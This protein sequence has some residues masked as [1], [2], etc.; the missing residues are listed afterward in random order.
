[1]F[2]PSERPTLR[3]ADILENIDRIQAYAGGMDWP[4]FQADG[5]RRDAIERC[6]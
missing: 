3:F 2:V 5:M 6:L 1:V 4:A